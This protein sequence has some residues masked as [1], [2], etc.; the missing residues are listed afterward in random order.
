[1]MMVMSTTTKLF[2]CS[3]VFGCGGWHD[4]AAFT[5]SRLFLLPGR[6][7]SHSSSSHSAQ[8]RFN[9]VCVDDAAVVLEW[10]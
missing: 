5:R 9:I 8:Y 10:G 1:M 3:S 6:S 7:D 4:W 2:V